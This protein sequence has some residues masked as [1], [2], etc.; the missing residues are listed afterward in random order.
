MTKL[1]ISA[2]SGEGVARF[3]AVVLALDTRITGR[4]R[5]TMARLP[6][7][8]IQ[9]KLYTEYP[10]KDSDLVRLGRVSSEKCWKRY[11]EELVLYCCIGFDRSQMVS[12][13]I[14]TDEGKGIF[15]WDRT[16]I[17]CLTGSTKLGDTMRE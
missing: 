4:I 16:V 3:L 7:S 9:S 14:E 10:S 11:F 1:T 6:T 13:L 8:M 12:G 5:R 15:S 2:M 17:D